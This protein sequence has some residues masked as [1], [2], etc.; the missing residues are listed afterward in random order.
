MASWLPDELAAARTRA[1]LTQDQVAAA[2]GWS[3]A[4]VSRIEAGLRGVKPGDLRDLLAFYG[5]TDPEQ[6]TDLITIAQAERSRGGPV[7]TTRDAHDRARA[8][9]AQFI[10]RAM[11]NTDLYDHTEHRTVEEEVALERELL[12]IVDRLKGGK[13]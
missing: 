12:H 3:A 6:V 7:A 11:E 10:T 1:G 2:M 9:A 8:L 13:P 5:V 4:K